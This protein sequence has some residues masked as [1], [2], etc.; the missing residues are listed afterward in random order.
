MSKLLWVIYVGL[1]ILGVIFVAYG[2][3]GYFPN[4]SRQKELLDRR[5]K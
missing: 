2:A 3:E 4:K 5:S 1:G